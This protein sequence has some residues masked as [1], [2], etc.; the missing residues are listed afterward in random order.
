MTKIQNTKRFE[1]EKSEFRI[2]PGEALA[3]PG[4]SILHRHL[5]FTIISFAN[6]YK[7]KIPEK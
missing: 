5:G 2:C 7:I 1:F 3:C 4:C 6:N